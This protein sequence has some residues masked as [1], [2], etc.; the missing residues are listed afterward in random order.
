MAKNGTLAKSQELQPSFQTTTEQITIGIDLGDRFSHCCVLGPDGRIL[1]EG[2]LRS[3]PE[4]MARHFRDLPSSRIAIEVGT[5][6]RWLS[7]L[8][9][10][11]GHEV[12]VANPRN[13]RMIADSIRKS[14]Q[15][16]AHMLAKLARVDPKLLS[17]IVHRKQESYPDIIQL[18][19]RDLL[20]KNRT[21]L[22]NA[23]RGVLKSTGLRLS[24]CGTS[25]FP[26]KAAM[27]VPDELK[28]SLTPLLETISHLNKQIYSLDKAI[29]STAQNRYPETNRLRQ[30]SGVGSITA[31]QYVLTIGD[32]G[33]FAH[34][35]DVPAYLGLTPRRHQSGSVEQQLR[36]S[37]AGNKQLRS[38]LVQ[39]A[40]YLLGRFGPD[41]D[42]KRWGTRMFERG[43]K[44]SKKRAIVAVARKL[45]VL[46]HRLWVTGDTYHPLYNVAISSVTP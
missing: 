38:L 15:V 11:W 34:S 6:S 36:I 3:T 14:D 46:L 23:V 32:P 35:R 10:Q 30:I 17:P 45:A 9:A 44:N 24:P 22:M 20:V 41:S 43:G 40:Q 18:K 13:L 27:C 1:T 37:K 39:C 5:H 4:T 31:L 33:R 7:Q 21:R 26:S 42:L 29:E 2:R 28:P 8:L 25:C 19:A 16:D 12:I